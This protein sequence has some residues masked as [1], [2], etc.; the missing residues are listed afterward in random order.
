M[1]EL[2]EVEVVRRSLNELIT[3]SKINK[4]SIF[5]KILRYKISK[6]FKKSI[7]GQK[8]ISIIKKRK[9]FTN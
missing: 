3:G 2:P 8:I 9:I 1:P 7:Q 4:V 5:N 6:K